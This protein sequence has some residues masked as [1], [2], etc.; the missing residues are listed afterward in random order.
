V[1]FPQPAPF[2]QPGLI[3]P[4]APRPTPP[5]L[6]EP[7][8]EENTIRWRRELIYEQL[9]LARA[10]IALSRAAY[11]RALEEE[12]AAQPWLTRPIDLV[13]L[14]RVNRALRLEL[15]ALDRFRLWALELYWLRRMVL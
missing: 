12:G 3:P 13:G 11:R 15:A 14:P 6:G 4:P 8:A 7:V 5:R 10:E 2:P 9:E 1:P